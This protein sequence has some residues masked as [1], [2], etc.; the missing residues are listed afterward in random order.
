METV[1]S[2][3]ET[4]PSFKA[5]PQSLTTQTYCM[6]AIDWLQATISLLQEHQH[7][8]GEVD[9]Y[10][11]Y[12]WSLEVKEVALLMRNVGLGMMKMGQYVRDGKKSNENQEAHK[13][14][15]ISITEKAVDHIRTLYDQFLA[16]PQAPLPAWKHQ[17]SPLDLI[18]EQMETIVSQIKKVQRS[19]NKLDTIAGKFDAFRER[20]QEVLAERL[21]YA[22]GLTTLLPELKTS[23]L[24]VTD[25]TI[26]KLIVFVDK[27]VLKLEGIVLDEQYE[28][29]ALE[30]MELL[31]LPFADQAGKLS[32][33][34][35]DILSEVSN[36]TASRLWPEFRSIDK[37][38]SKLLDRTGIY[39]FQFSNQLK[40]KLDAQ[41]VKG[42][43]LSQSI[44]KLE[45]EITPV[46][47]KELIP[48]IEKVQK[49]L[50]TL[51]T[52]SQLFDKEDNFLPDASLIEISSTVASNLVERYNESKVVQSVRERL[53]QSSNNRNKRELLQTSISSVLNQ[54]DETEQYSLFKRTGY[55]GASFTV[56]RT[57]KEETLN[58]H[59]A[60]WQEGFGGALCIR[61]AYGSGRST[62]LG[63]FMSGL[64]K[65]RSYHINVGESIDV[66]GHKVPINKDLVS[67]LKSVNK[68]SG[69]DPVV[70][71]IDNFESFAENPEEL[72]E[73]FR[74]TQAFI[75]REARHIYLAVVLT[76][77]SYRRFS[78]LF[79]LEEI[80][81]TTVVADGASDDMITQALLT[82][83]QAVFKHQQDDSFRQFNKKAKQVVRF[84]RGNMGLAMTLWGINSSDNA[85]LIHPGFDEL[86]E[87]YQLILEMTAMQGQ[88]QTS[89]SNR[90]LDYAQ[91]VAFKDGITTLLAYKILV[92]SGSG[93]VM[94]HPEMRSLVETSLENIHSQ[95]S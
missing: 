17:I 59:F 57:K 79:P 52:T 6:A 87:R 7:G 78:M 4:I 1:D 83:A 80:F 47:A 68:Y 32:V 18:V 53:A 28:D 40:A 41:E 64:V 12:V 76:N 63:K 62:L 23:C 77:Y 11:Q 49:Q 15:S 74:Q 33:K 8:K 85:G 21:E 3:I 29:I 69:R 20:Y 24:E 25:A 54:E 93:F 34:R 82:R 43:E 90:M 51:L 88:L 60:L 26:N 16:S 2:S 46:I 73:L 13:Q 14:D 45:N 5:N 65:I 36:W 89:F 58:K 91:A 81:T 50:T 67:A 37:H 61:G 38:L 92:R 94:I 35:I 86:I 10:I 66:E 56:T 75:R 72:F 95:R 71:A 19:D 44:K 27:Q 39:L 22:K 30:D 48:E 9:Q 31:L 84:A 55:M 42:K 70:V